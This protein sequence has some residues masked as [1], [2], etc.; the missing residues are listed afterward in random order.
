M[1]AF[2]F[3]TNKGE[4]MKNKFR[5][6]GKIVLILLL[7]GL[8]LYL[9]YQDETFFQ[10]QQPQ[11]EMARLE[12]VRILTQ[13]LNSFGG[14]GFDTQGLKAF[15]MHFPEGSAEYLDYGTY[16]E[17]MAC[18]GQEKEEFSFERKY[19]EDFTV[20]AKDWYEAYGK[21][22]GKLGLQEEIRRETLTLLCRNE[23]LTGDK[24]LKEGAVMDLTGQVYFPISEELKEES[25]A[26]IEA[27]VHGDRLLT[28]VGRLPDEQMIANVFIMERDSFG[29]RVFYE[30]YEMVI[31][32]ADSLQADETGDCPEQIADITFGEG[33]GKEIRVK[34]EKI[35]GKLLSYRE[36]GLEIEGHGEYELSENCRG[37][38]LYDTLRLAEAEEL[39]IG[40][41][42]SDF[43]IEDGR[44]CAF[45]IVRKEEMKQIRVA[46]KNSQTGGLFHDEIAV[47]CGEGLTVHFG[48]YEDRQEEMLAPDE[49]LTVKSGSDYLK[50][51]RMEIKTGINTGKIRVESEMR[52]QG[53]P[54]YRGTLELLDTPEGIVLINEL[55][56]EE[57]LYSVV[58]SE[59]PASYPLEALKAQAICART[60]GYRYLEQPGY[61]SYGAHV[62]DSVGYQVYNNIAENVN[63]T[64]AVKETA[65]MVL[66]YG[67]EL[68]NAYYY[69]TSCGFGADAGVW[70]EDQKEKMPY[71]VS[72]YIGEGEPEGEGGDEEASPAGLTGEEVFE[73]YISSEDENAYEREEPWFRW[74]Y[75]VE[76]MDASVI[77]KRLR[78]RY[79]AVP[80]KILCYTGEE[81][82][83]QEADL[84]KSENFSS[85][86]P[87]KV[88]KVYEISC[89]KRKEGGVI[90]EL[91]LYT[92]KG[93]YK[94]VSE[95]NI[96]YL[97]N[98][99]GAVVRN[100]GSSYESNLL[101]PSA[102]FTIDTVKSGKNVI[103]YTI[104]GGGYGHGVGMSQNGA[105]AMGLAGMSGEDI[106]A[107][108]FA[109]CHLEN[110]YV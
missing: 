34:E 66:Y 79:L 26:T 24:R 37:Y 20:L 86:E 57:Y 92:D 81:K 41:D 58:P 46:I 106:L 23:G 29:L 102:Y 75:R 103:G 77:G 84:K 42:F 70:N 11:G 33:R 39:P 82:E 101:L 31:P 59:M 36:N 18:L 88:Q 56:M 96:R 38:Q 2:S 44:I 40:Y 55:P 6:C 16:K 83:P 104:I 13:E 35:S 21:L 61:Q 65:G 60:Y 69:S 74:E 7:T 100:D 3:V 30:D 98:L 109:E 1:A 87:E 48:K 99:G 28:L 43:V 47:S 53:I 45:L 91:L 9:I 17:L 107:F 19:R 64:K 90:D 105:R 71:L 32:L 85:R 72:K 76:D 63:S 93:L 78:E 94:I 5:L 80:D 89:L 50:D 22:L 15:W 10:L 25:F 12:D 27:Y 52:A 67:D 51:A 54:A 108:Y 14:S 95:Y 97:L 68:V 8:L 4:L 62:D 110:V 49:I 73:A